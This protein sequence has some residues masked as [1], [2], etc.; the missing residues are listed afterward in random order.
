MIFT[1]LSLIGFV[2][3]P[4]QHQT[5]G[6]QEEDTSDHDKQGVSLFQQRQRGRG[7]R[8]WCYEETSERCQMIAMACRCSKGSLLAL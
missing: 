5:K 7:K 4:C 6:V 1:Y 2:S 8:V 3:T